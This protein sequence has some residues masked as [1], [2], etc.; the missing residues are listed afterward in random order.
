MSQP[1][2]TGTITGFF[3]LFA[4]VTVIVI[5][6]GGIYLNL[7]RSVSL[8]YPAGDL[9]QFETGFLGTSASRASDFSLLAYIVLLLPGMLFGFRFARRKLFAPHHKMTMTFI[10]TVNWF[11]ILYLMAVNYA[12]GVAP[13]VPSKLSDPHVLIP[14]VH[15]LAGVTAQIIATVSLIRMWFEYRLPASLRYEPIKPQ[16]RLTLALWLIAAALGITTYLAF[17]GVPFAGKS[18]PASP[19]GA[20]PA[21]TVDVAATKD[22]TQKPAATKDAAPQATKDATQSPAATKD[23]VPTVPASLFPAASVTPAATAAK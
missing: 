2:Y 9:R 16:M 15:L 22:A 5:V 18:S 1:K 4:L 8:G 7:V 23:A 10:T 21:A 6:L 11:I 17:Y 19:A 20:T 12:G 13:G 3:V 14:S